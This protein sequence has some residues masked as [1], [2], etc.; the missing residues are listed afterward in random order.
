MLHSNSKMLWCAWEYF[1]KYLRFLQTTNWKSN[2]GLD[3][4]IINQ[5]K[6]LRICWKEMFPTNKWCFEKIYEILCRDKKKINIW[7]K[8][9]QRT[10]RKYFK[11]LKLVMANLSPASSGHH[12]KLTFTGQLWTKKLKFKYCQAQDQVPL[13]Y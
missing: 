11:K 13:S 12:P 9:S 2:W 3:Y 6:H 1:A 4:F 10:I 7:D 5:M 8:L